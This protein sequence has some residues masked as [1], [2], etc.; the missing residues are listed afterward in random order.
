MRTAPATRTAASN[1][2]RAR[3]GHGSAIPS[4]ASAKHTPHDGKYNVRSAISTS[5][6]ITMLATGDTVTTS[7]ISPRASPGT[8][9]RQCHAA[10]PAAIQ[11]A[12]PSRCARVNPVETTSSPGE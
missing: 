10:Q 11:R 3:D 6:G 5:V 1:V 2:T 4:A 12:R 9:A 7:Q 8:R